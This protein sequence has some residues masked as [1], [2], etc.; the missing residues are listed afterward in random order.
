MDLESFAIVAALEYAA[1]CFRPT[2][3][4]IFSDSQSSVDMFESLNTKDE[5]R[6]ILIMAFVNINEEFGIHCRVFHISRQDNEISDARSKFEN[7]RLRTM[8]ITTI[9]QLETIMLC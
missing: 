2:N 3:V 9:Q 4:V 1:T 8:K 5:N 6:N 7:H